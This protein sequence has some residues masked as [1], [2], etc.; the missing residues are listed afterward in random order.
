MH[1]V[2]VAYPKDVLIRKIDGIMREMGLRLKTENIMDIIE[3]YGGK[4][5]I[6]SDIDLGKQFY[7]L[8]FYHI[9]KSQKII[10]MML[11]R[12]DSNGNTIKRLT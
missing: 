7:N 9:K 6:A 8:L 4:F 1:A 3:G 12:L 2:T 10:Y 5:G 11:C